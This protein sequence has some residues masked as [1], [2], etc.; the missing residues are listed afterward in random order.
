MGHHLQQTAGNHRDVR[1]Y[2]LLCLSCVDND[3]PYGRQADRLMPETNSFYGFN[4]NMS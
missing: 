2:N 3:F 4:N 1:A